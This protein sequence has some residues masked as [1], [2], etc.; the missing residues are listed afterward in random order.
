M[1]VFTRQ[2]RFFCLVALAAATVS[3][4]SALA[5]GSELKNSSVPA[6]P[7]IVNAS[8]ENL[9]DQVL[10]R[11]YENLLLEDLTE[12][13]FRSNS[14]PVLSSEKALSQV[15]QE[16]KESADKTE[17][18]AIKHSEET[19]RKQAKTKA[20]VASVTKKTGPASVEVLENA[21]PALPGNEPGA[22]SLPL[23]PTKPP[24]PET[25]TPAAAEPSP[26][27]LAS[28]SSSTD[29]SPNQVKVGLD[30]GERHLAAGE[31][32]LA[33]NAF[34]K[35][36]KQAPD[37]GPANVGLAKALEG[38]HLAA[39]AAKAHQAETVQ[40]AQTEQAQLAQ[41]QQQDK[42][43]RLSVLGYEH[44]RGHRWEEALNSFSAVLT[45]DPNNEYA[46]NGFSFAQQALQEEQQQK[47]VQAAKGLGAEA[48]E[49]LVTAE[50]FYQAGDYAR[51]R[52]YY[53]AVLRSN[54][55]HPH[56]SR[57]MAACEQALAGKLP[58]WEDSTPKTD[59]SKSAPGAVPTGR[60]SARQEETDQLARKPAEDAPQTDVLA[61]KAKS[62][63][64][65]AKGVDARLLL[66]QAATDVNPPSS[67]A[68][69]Q[70]QHDA[71][72]SSNS[73]DTVSLT[74][75]RYL[76]RAAI[77]LQKGEYE[78]A[79]AD[80][81]A[82]LEK[83]SAN[84]HAKEGLAEAE[85][86]LQ[87]KQTAQSSSEDENLES[88]A[89]DRER[90]K[91]FL[92]RG[93]ARFAQGLIVEAHSDW[94][95]AIQ[96]D[97]TLVQAETMLKET[98]KEYDEALAKH[99]SNED[100]AKQ[101][102]E[103]IA[104]LDLDVMGVS[105]ADFQ[106]AE[107]LKTISTISGFNIVTGPGVHG[108]VTASVK[109]GVKLRELLDMLL[110]VNGFHWERKGW[111]IY[112]TADLRTEI[113]PLTEL[114]FRKLDQIGRRDDELQDP[115]VGL[116]DVVLGT[117]ATLVGI[118]GCEFIL[119][120]QLL[121]LIVT[122]SSQNLQKVK[123][124]L[125]KLDDYVV[126]KPVYLTKTFSLD[127][128]IADDL[129]TF[130]HIQ[131]YGTKEDVPFTADGSYLLYD[132]KNN[133][134]TIRDT[135]QNI[136]KVVNLIEDENIINRIR[137]K[138]L[139]ARQ[140]VVVGPAPPTVDKA[141]YRYRAE[142]QLAHFKTILEA[143]LYGAEGREKHRAEGK[144]IKDYMWVDDNDGD[145]YGQV[146]IT[147]VDTPENITRA[148]DF[149]LGIGRDRDQRIEVIRINHR[150]VD[151]LNAQLRSIITGRLVKT[152]D[153]GGNQDDPFINQGNRQ[154]RSPIQV[155]TIPDP[156]SKTIIA[157]A[158][159]QKDIETVRGLIKQLDV[160]VEQVTVEARLVE[161]NKLELEQLGFDVTMTDILDVDGGVDGGPGFTLSRALLDFARNANGTA[162]TFRTLP[163]LGNTQVSLIINALSQLTRTEVLS[164]P[165]VTTI[166]AEPA[167]VFVGDRITYISGLNSSQVQGTNNMQTSYTTD[168]EEIGVDLTV[169][170]TVTGDGYIEMDIEP[171]LSSVKGRPTFLVPSNPGVGGTGTSQIT[172]GKPDILER[173]A[174]VSVRVKDGETI[175]IGGMIKDTNL[176]ARSHTPILSQIPGLEWLFTDKN[177]SRELD[178][179]LIFVTAHIVK[180]G[181]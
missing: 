41:K 126:D 161:V 178:T 144:M 46:R 80:F 128:D 51:A 18:P 109:P 21:L 159:T 34:K 181:V 179:L 45:L 29:S 134:L 24:L 76:D 124:F 89:N 84:Q 3:L 78:K 53:A 176:G 135:P 139:T 17:A 44:T 25:P 155:R 83:D 166:S 73:L 120:R 163:G 174:T 22:P 36:L 157:M 52:E 87:R 48:Q 141:A 137:K 100:A 19:P 121:A 77:Y 162:L 154:N 150:S 10:G 132:D 118:P 152:G 175:V 47:M 39:Q 16:P 136:K 35:V 67:P 2:K 173:R 151:S 15:S 107:V 59:L 153:Q 74:P 106:L 102:A 108:M 79:K 72:T 177:D 147:I 49:A 26:S 31:W 40:R 167:S 143:L 7:A 4:R 95:K 66:A 55:N 43:D 70:M 86:G 138:T 58:G 165:K 115:S 172:I 99:K 149:L 171:N 8:S 38:K 123:E 180:E 140:F 105:F 101:E 32:D 130:I 33:E 96:L 85:Q 9:E 103:A 170:P 129:Y 62:K 148:E 28:M 116:R 11:L 60:E 94:Q 88:A 61:P 57:R 92:Q 14:P 27:P 145:K 20:L 122:D 81:K 97:P 91:R 12:V 146:E 113:F 64:Q 1:I 112:V 75:E 50:E 169:T 54:P 56:A 114:Q 168:S 131:L 93:N 164:A 71:A 133:L 119:S 65:A 5:V 127:P 42:I 63:A 30:E 156:L 110:T 82:V 37:H 68:A 23:P 13:R 6:G 160:P 98:Q 111:D 117:N 104:K 90:A 142:K 69:P 158:R 125:S